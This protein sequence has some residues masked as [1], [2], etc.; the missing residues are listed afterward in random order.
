[1]KFKSFH[2]SVD[3]HTDPNDI[4]NLGLPTT[5]HSSA[6][7]FHTYDLYRMVQKILESF[8][9]VKSNLTGLTIT[10]KKER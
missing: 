6:G 3:Y 9:D 8:W 5:K 7:R 1:M 10:I 4:N 2:V